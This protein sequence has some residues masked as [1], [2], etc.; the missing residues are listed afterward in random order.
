LGQRYNLAKGDSMVDF[1][2]AQ[3]TQLRTLTQPFPECVM[4]E[5]L[6]RLF[7]EN[8][9]LLF[10]SE[11][12]AAR[13]PSKGPWTSWSDSPCYTRQNANERSLPHE[14]EQG[15]HHIEQD[16]HHKRLHEEWFRLPPS[17]KRKRF[18]PF[19]V[20]PPSHQSGNDDR[21]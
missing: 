20:P 5:N 19:S 17:E 3:A 10:K 18:N 16:R 11:N 1:F 12:H 9:L 7:P 6:M 15:R 8:I 2:M 13:G 21:A 14:N 4:V